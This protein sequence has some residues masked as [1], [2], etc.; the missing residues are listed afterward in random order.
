MSSSSGPSGSCAHCC[1]VI[2]LG[3][4]QLNAIACGLSFACAHCGKSLVLRC[5]Q[6]LSQ[7]ASRARTGRI[8]AAL[9][10]LNV[11][12][13]PLINM[14]M[15][16]SIISFR[17]QMCLSLLAVALIVLGGTCWHFRH[18]RVLTLQDIVQR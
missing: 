8:L 13:I 14:L 3:E 7:L 2:A 6:Q 1:A 15:Q 12:L 17:M 4:E 11:S 5:P 16:L 10:V 18:G 9:V